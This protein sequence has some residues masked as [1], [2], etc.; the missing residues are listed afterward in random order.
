MKNI[1]IIAAFLILGAYLAYTYIGTPASTEG[2][3]TMIGQSKRVGSN[4]VDAL[5][6]VNP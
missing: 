3:N 6:L 5:K 2:D 1:L 4:G